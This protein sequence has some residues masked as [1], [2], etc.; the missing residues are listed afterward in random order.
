M[1]W[2]LV[3]AALLMLTFLTFSP[4]P[5]PSELEAYEADPSL[6]AILNYA[7]QQ[8]L[9]FGTEFVY[10]YGPLGYLIFPYFYPHAE[11]LRMVVNAAL[12][13]AV[14]ASLCLVAWRL[15]RAWRYALLAGFA[16]TAANV[17]LRLDFVINVGLLCWG[18]LCM[19][20]S[21]RRLGLCL[22]AFAALAV[23]AALAKISFFF[24]AGGSL[25]ALAADLVL[26]GRCRAAVGLVI[27]SAGTFLAGWRLA[28]QHLGNLGV[29]VSN[30]LAMV[31]GYN[32]ALGWEELS[33]AWRGGLVL[34]AVLLALLILRALTVFQKP[35][36]R[37]AWR[38]ALV[39]GWVFA[40]TFTVWKHGFVRGYVSDVLGCVGFMLVLALVVQILPCA[41]PSPRR[42]ALIL[43]AVCSLLAA[44][45][46]QLLWN[47]SPL[48]SLY[49][50]GRLMA[51]NLRWLVQPGEYLRCMN[52]SVEANRTQAQLPHLRE[53]IGTSSVDL[54]GRRQAYAI[55]NALNYHPRPSPQS[56]AVCNAELMR[57]NQEF[58]LSPAAPE[59]VL[60]ELISLDRKLPALEDAWT[61]RTLLA[62]YQ[63]V[64]SEGRFLL[65]KAKSAEPPKLTL[66]REGSVSPGQ[67]ID[68]RASGDADLWMEIHL[69]PSWAGRLRQFFYR[70]PV[71]RIAA[72]GEPRTKLLIRNRAPASMLSA[73]FL[74]S[75]LLLNNQDVLNLYTSGP[76][77][78]PSAY[79]IELL[80]GEERFWQ[81]DIRFRIYRIENRLGR[82]VTEAEARQ[83]SD[84]TSR[85]SS[86]E[87]TIR[88]VA[89]A[90]PSTQARPRPFTVFRSPKWHPTRPGDG[91]LM[92][93]LTFAV[94]LAMPIGFMIL[95]VPFARRARRRQASVGW[96]SLL[97][98]NG[99][100]LLF[101]LSLLLLAGEVY[102]RFVYD[103]T[104]SLGYTKVCE[105]WVQRHWHVNTAGCRDDVEYSTTIAPRKRRITFIGDSFAA[106]H[107]I[108]NV[109]DR[110]EN[111]LR[112]AHPEWE[113]HVLANVGLDTGA[114]QILLNRA[115]AKGYQLDEVVLVYCLNDVGDLMPEES[116]AYEQ[117]FANLDSGG[118][119]VRH[120][121]FVNL[122]YHRYKARQIP[123]LRNYFPFVRAAYSG[124]RWDL[125]KQR[126]K[127]FHDAVEAHGGRL[128]VMTFPFLQALGP[129]YEYQFV[130]DELD[131]FWLGLQV[132]HLDLL[133][134]YK[135]LQ[136]GQL[137]VNP[138]DAH[139]NEYANRLAAE[140]LNNF[141]A[142]H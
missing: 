73:G 115:I 49:Q 97:L 64:G 4:A 135:G 142:R 141:L 27:A 133:S 28:G 25:V 83:W 22:A 7:H 67:P 111:L 61:L 131:Q 47:P 110:F 23:F 10:T 20:E 125:Q 96:Q 18:L 19:V 72:W 79:S 114:E 66:L 139:P 84:V 53:I 129:R 136:P 107:G 80:P 68:M 42:W 75:P 6:S 36:P 69:E 37:L 31:R 43:G 109:Q 34:A 55:F 99:L 81:P 120:S 15:P 11:A 32:A 87:T 54:F 40:L 140:A 17:D 137:T 124:P 26:R 116:Q 118:W 74:A 51:S 78:H 57:L 86:T 63:P 108:K 29:F 89:L 127:A 103:T 106:G 121:Y 70:P 12:C 62:N 24:V 41:A 91:P 93:S 123:M 128:A 90:Q 85:T 14:A 130:H 119:F 1:V 33:V 52:A 138:Y 100:M 5:P 44:I 59:F 82:C 126:L 35:E 21:G 39:C 30:A 50:P 104:D 117:I 56:Y 105:R 38:R 94:F 76:M 60:F 9:Q 16:W 92:E 113:I 77:K 48:E 95:F 132:P 88:P 58:F 13:F 45:L 46:L 112:T 134:V 8:N 2:P 71:V 122:L 98:G 3:A 65:L 102:F 101:F